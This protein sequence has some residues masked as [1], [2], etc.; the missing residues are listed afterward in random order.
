MTKLLVL[1]VL[2]WTGACANTVKQDKATTP[3]GKITGAKP[4]T[5]VE[6]ATTDTGI[7]TYPGGDRIDWKVVELPAKKR[8]TLEIRLTWVTPRPGLQLGFDVYDQW[9]TFVMSSTGKKNKAKQK[10]RLRL[11][12]VENASGKYFV[13]VYALQRGDA[14]RY[15]LELTFREGDPTVVDWP[16]I[17]VTDPPR[18]PDL[19]GIEEPCDEAN[20]KTTVKAC[21]SICWPGA[22]ATWP[23]CSK[24]CTAV[25]PNPNIPICARTAECPATPDRRFDKCT[26][27][28]FK[29]CPDP[30]RPD[31]DNPNCDHVTVPPVY[32]VF[33]GYLAYGNAYDL[34]LDVTGTVEQTW[35][36]NL[37]VGG[38]RTQKPTTDKVFAGSS[39]QI[40]STSARGATTHV[41]VR[42]VN[43]SADQLRNN[44][45][46]KF[47]P[48]PRKSSSVRP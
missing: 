45:W 25:P 22:P 44:K 31:P 3:D 1:A 10:S 17:P 2:V 36:A 26:A 12:A 23:G 43:V 29:A 27:D 5:L 30:A 18:L 8:G 48:P 38:D 34:E 28:K 42:V 13:R 37:L 35:S 21:R 14:G 33:I 41:K 32:G 6:G 47:S 40:L 19:P 11:A 46:V 4:L 15:K 24:T 9:N 39:A 16:N 20:P 7:V